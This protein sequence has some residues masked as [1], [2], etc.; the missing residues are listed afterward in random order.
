MTAPETLLTNE[1]EARSWMNP[2]VTHGYWRWKAWLDKILAA[3]LLVLLSPVILI[4]MVLVRLTSKGSPLYRQARLGRGGREFLI[5]KIRSM[6]QDCERQSGA[7]WSLPGDPRVTPVGR[8][9]RALHIDELPQLLNVLKGDMSLVGPRPERPEIITQ[10]ER[11]IPQLNQRLEIKPGLTGLAQVQLP[12]DV[13][14]ESVRAKLAVDLYYIRNAGVML[15]LCVM[16]A[17]ALKVFGVPFQTIHSFLGFMLADIVHPQK[18]PPAPMPE[19]VDDTEDLETLSGR[20][21]TAPS[22]S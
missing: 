14:L 8:V 16:A 18:L 4:A 2:P 11:A 19:P 13:G 22:A 9:L 10:F 20:Y 17:T 21:S 5:Y 7:V 3:L 15:D 6:Y 12:P 1:P